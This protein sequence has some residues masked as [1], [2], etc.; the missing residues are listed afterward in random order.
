MHPII[1]TSM[2]VGTVAVNY[3]NENFCLTSLTWL[4]CMVCLTSLTRFTCI[5]CLTG[6]T[7]LICKLV[8]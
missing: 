4:I 5:T 3:L 1:Q 2:A 7:W 8:V 6:L